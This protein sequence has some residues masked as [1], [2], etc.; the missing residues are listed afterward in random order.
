MGLGCQL[1]T[2]PAARAPLRTTAARVAVAR[3]AGKRR[4]TTFYPH[5]APSTP[6]TG[7][8]HARG[9]SHSHQHANVPSP[10]NM[11]PT[12]RCRSPLRPKDR[13]V[14]KA[15]PLRGV[16]MPCVVADALVTPAPIHLH[17]SRQPPWL[18]DHA[19]MLRSIFWKRAQRA[20]IRRTPLRWRMCISCAPPSTPLS[21]RAVSYHVSAHYVASQR[22][23]PHALNAAP[24]R[25]LD[26]LYHAR[27]VP[28]PPCAN[29]QRAHERSP[30]G[31]GG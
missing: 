19:W 14:V 17:P 20:A 22:R 23:L 28:H 4:L 18:R 11:A 13:R 6:R 21:Y 16:G 5:G 2:R 25:S 30:C 31:L 12:L 9:M 1:R 3:P 8:R 10:W 24:T 26:H 27:R 7:Q 29:P 15:Q